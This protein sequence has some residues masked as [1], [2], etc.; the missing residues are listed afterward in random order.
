MK[1][2]WAKFFVLFDEQMDEAQKL[3]NQVFTE[4]RDQLRGVY[5]SSDPCFAV[6]AC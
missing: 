3:I 4:L 6:P 5:S 2:Q 1:T